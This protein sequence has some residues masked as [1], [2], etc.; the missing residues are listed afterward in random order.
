MS[1]TKC[2]DENRISGGRLGRDRSRRA[3]TSSVVAVELIG[4]RFFDYSCIGLHSIFASVSLSQFNGVVLGLSGASRLDVAYALVRAASRLV[5][6][7]F[8]RS[9]PRE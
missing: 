6:T 4:A 3:L 7:L 5:S 9:A 1:M 8:E 2:P